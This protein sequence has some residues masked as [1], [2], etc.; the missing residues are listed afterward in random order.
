MKDIES[1][2]KRLE[3]S[4]V[5]PDD[6]PLLTVCHPQEERGPN[7]ECMWLVQEIFMSFADQPGRGREYLQ[8]CEDP[9]DIERYFTRHGI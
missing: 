7:G 1:R 9:E 3:K 8:V 5:K 6:V 4:I 2:I